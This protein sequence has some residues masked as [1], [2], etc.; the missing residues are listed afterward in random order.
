MNES[1]NSTQ[2][3]PL[4]E[5]LSEGIKVLKAG[6]LEIEDSSE[7]QNLAS[8]NEASDVSNLEKTTEESDFL[9]PQDSNTIPRTVTYLG[10]MMMLMN[11]A[12]MMTFSFSGL[13][14]R[15]LGIPNVGIGFLEGLAEAMSNIMKFSSGVL[16]DAMKRRR[17][18][19][20]VGYTM[21]ILARPVMALA[22]SFQMFFL[23]KV[24]ERLGNGIQGTPRDAIVADITPSRRIGAA[25][26]L[27]RS[28]ATIGSIIGAG[29]G[30]F[31]MYM[32]NDDMNTVFWF[33]C[34]PSSIAF[35]IL[36]F[37][38]K[39]PKRHQHSA[40][41]SEIPLPAPKR[42]ITYNIKNLKFLG[43]AFWLL[44]AVNAVFMMARVGEQF[45]VL[46]AKTNHALSNTYAPIIFI[47]FN[48]GW[49]LTSYPIGLLGDRMNRYWILILGIILL[50]FSSIILATATSLTILFIGVLFWGFQYGITMNI[51]SSLIGQIVPE[52]LRGTGFG[53]YYIINAVTI[54]LGE[55]MAGHIADQHG[56]HAAFTLSSIIALTALMVLI[57]V[58]A[59]KTSQKKTKKSSPKAANI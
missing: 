6:I 57:I 37:G 33:A 20:F 16:S 1:Q 32:T 21:S 9:V 28:L 54:I 18:V 12:F 10:I 34:I 3:N 27:K 53:I 38:V 25:Y 5:H 42:K 31:I 26:G 8:I 35:M 23:S 24:M 52:N 29:I 36:I 19:M 14:L 46:H 13:Y 45:I 11:C 59:I 30:S 22:G 58:M 2:C 50:V 40:V 4:N 17:P 44:M 55:S 7:K 41:S 39:E 49:C 43:S 48:F 15:S 51:F 56:Y 47:I